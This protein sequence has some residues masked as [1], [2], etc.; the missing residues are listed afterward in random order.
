M[1]VR[2]ESEVAQSCLTLSDPMDCSPPGSSNPWD[3]PGK[4][5]GVGYHCL[6]RLQILGH[7]KHSSHFTKAHGF[8]D[9]SVGKESTYQ[10]GEAGDVGL[11]PEW[12]RYPAGG[13]GDPL[14]V[15]LPEKSHGRRSLVGYSP[16]GHKES[17][18]TEQLSTEM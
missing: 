7:V 2:S 12:R 6:L 9:G 10:A 16:K 18:T 4:S 1:K 5:T 8:P 14:S 13:N 15:F 3:S 17:D 11:V